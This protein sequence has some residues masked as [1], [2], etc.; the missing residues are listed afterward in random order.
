MGINLKIKK[1]DLY[2]S[3]NFI[4]SFFISLIAFTN[5]FILSQLFRVFKYVADG[6]MTLNDGI[7][8]ML[9]MLPEIFI[10]VTPLAV[11]LG[12]LMMIN[13]MAGNLEIISLKTSG[14]S[15]KRIIRFPVII[16]FIVSIVIF[17][18]YGNI[19]PEAERRMKELKGDVISKTIPKEKWNAF[20]RNLSNNNIYMIEYINIQKGEAKNIELIELN[21]G[22]TEIEK[23]IV[24]KTGKYNKETSNW[25]LKDVV[26]NDIKNSKTI[27]KSFYIAEKFKDAPQSFVTYSI[28]EKFLITKELKKEIK[29]LRTTG[30]DIRSEMVEFARRY[31]F[32]FISF[33][34]SFIGLSLGSKYVRGNSARNIVLCMVFGYGYYIVQ[35]SFETLGKNSLM[36]PFISS[37]LPNVIFLIIGIYFINKA[38]Y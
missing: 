12:S 23:V 19:Y 21:K 4:K 14:I 2:M 1:L 16:S 22:F 15:F 37:W 17:Y 29:K 11:L 26:V 34:I 10:N 9:N 31:S 30:G 33:I 32:P 3:K 5:I 18:V 6:R 35:A 38:E 13:K 8:Y 7:F 20:L 24:A 25:Q 27:K 28:S 36:N